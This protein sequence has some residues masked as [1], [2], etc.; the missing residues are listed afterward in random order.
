MHITLIV[1][2]SNNYRKSDNSICLR[3]SDSVVKTIK[4]NFRIKDIICFYKL[5]KGILQMVYFIKYNTINQSYQ[6]NQFND[7]FKW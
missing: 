1:R 6:S 5:L 3:I 2:F 4:V 7:L